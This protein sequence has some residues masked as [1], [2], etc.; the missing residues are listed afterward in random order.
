MMDI[1]LRYVILTKCRVVGLMQPRIDEAGAEMNDDEPWVRDTLQRMA[2]E[3]KDSGN[4]IDAYYKE[5]RIGAFVV[6]SASPYPA[7]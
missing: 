5:K 2:L 6:I 4:S 3:I 1:L 7:I